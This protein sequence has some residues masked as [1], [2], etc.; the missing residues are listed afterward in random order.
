MNYT[1]EQMDTAWQRNQYSLMLDQSL[2]TAMED[3]GRWMNANNLTNATAIPDFGKYVYTK[4]LKDVK[5]EAVN[6]L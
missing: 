1:D 5:P 2:I 4:G 6:I 3:E